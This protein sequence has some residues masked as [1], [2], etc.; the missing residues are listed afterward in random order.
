LTKFLNICKNDLAT[1]LLSI[2]IQKWII[3]VAKLQKVAKIH[4]NLFVNIVTILLAGKVVG[5][6]TLRPKNTSRNRYPKVIQLRWITKKLQ[7]GI[8]VSAVK[9]TSL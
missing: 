4:I 1:F 8:S 7:I 5:Q 9:V 3:K 2:Y 6:N